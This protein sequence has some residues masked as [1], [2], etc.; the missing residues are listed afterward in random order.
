MDESNNKENE[1]GGID[2]KYLMPFEQGRAPLFKFFSQGIDMALI[3]LMALSVSMFFWLGCPVQCV[4]A[5][6]H[7]PAKRCCPKLALL[8]KWLLNQFWRVQLK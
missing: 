3:L 7:T 1:G 8:R 5:V 2:A 4:L 6:V